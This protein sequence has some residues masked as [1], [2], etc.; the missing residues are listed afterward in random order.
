MK[1]TAATVTFP[2]TRRNHNLYY[3]YLTCEQP[4]NLSWKNA[5]FRGNARDFE[6]YNLNFA[7]GMDEV[8]NF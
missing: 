5:N 8:G 7:L 6:I 3:K 2:L 1:S 4:L